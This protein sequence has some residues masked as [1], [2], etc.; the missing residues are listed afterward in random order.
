MNN[1]NNNSLAVIYKIY[2]S[3]NIN[4]YNKSNIVKYLLKYRQWFVAPT[5]RLSAFPRQKNTFCII[6]KLH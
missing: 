1:Y 3:M 4:N 6:Y 5:L 2:D